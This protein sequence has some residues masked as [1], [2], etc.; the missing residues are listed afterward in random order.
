MQELALECGL[1]RGH[2]GFE[3][4]QVAHPW[5]AAVDPDLLLMDLQR[6]VQ[7]EELRLQGEYRSR[8]SASLW[9]ALPYRVW[10]AF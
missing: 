6:L 4:R 1:W 3:R 7:R 5:W 8:Y 10:T 9:N 2:R